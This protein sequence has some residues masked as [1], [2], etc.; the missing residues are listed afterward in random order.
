MKL[1]L[2]EDTREIPLTQGKVTIVDNEDY[3]KLTQY[4]W[5]F[6]GRYA[7]R[8]IPKTEASPRWMLLMHTAIMGKSGNGIITDHIDRDKL[9]NRKSN[10]R[11]CTHKQNTRNTKTR[12]GLSS[13]YK[14]VYWCKKERKWN[15]Q[16]RV[17]YKNRGL[18][19]FDVEK[20]AARAYDSA[21]KKDFGKFASCN[22]SESE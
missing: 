15:A 13:R 12:K 8:M 14:G 10:L 1:K 18:G 17:S 6:D 19:S 2:K 4:K 20:D 7:A 11:F 3:Q 22:L 16:I 21:A 9:N 5:F